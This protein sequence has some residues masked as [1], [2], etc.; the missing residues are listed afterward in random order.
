MGEKNKNKRVNDFH[1]CYCQYSGS[2]NELD[3]KGYLTKLTTGD[4]CVEC[5]RCE[6][7]QLAERNL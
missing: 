4:V 5:P 3:E 6:G 7:Q 1:C 2:L